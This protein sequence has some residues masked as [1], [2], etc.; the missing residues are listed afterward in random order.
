MFN[1]NTVFV[2]SVHAVQLCLLLNIDI[3][4]GA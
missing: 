4:S 2:Y 3:E 1:S